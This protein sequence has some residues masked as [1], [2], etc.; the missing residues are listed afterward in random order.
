MISEIHVEVEMDRSVCLMISRHPGDL[1]KQ[2]IE[3]SLTSQSL[4]YC[5]SGSLSFLI[6]LTSYHRWDRKLH[7]SRKICQVRA[8]EWTLVS[9]FDCLS[10][11]FSY[12]HFIVFTHILT[13]PTH[14]HSHVCT[15]GLLR[16]NTSDSPC[17]VWDGEWWE[18][19]ISFPQPEPEIPA[20]RQ[21]WAAE[22][23]RVISWIVY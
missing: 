12:W 7:S 21:Q 6:L 13:P 18:V 2:T 10:L 3:C 16:R 8:F 22:C 4:P 14:N 15:P 9:V 5:C 19:E 1:I 23:R 11:V 17:L 20:H